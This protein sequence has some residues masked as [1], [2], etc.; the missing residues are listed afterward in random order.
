[1]NRSIH[2]FSFLIFSLYSLSIVAILSAPDTINPNQVIRDGDTIVSAT[3]K[4]ELGFFS[5]GS[6]T[7]RY[8][9]IWYRK[10]VT[11]RTPIWVVNRESPLRQNSTSGVLMVKR[12]GQLVI[13]DES[14]NDTIWSTNT[15]RVAR[16]PVVQLLDSGNLVVRE[17]NDD[18]PENYIWQ[19]F[20]YPTDTFLSSMD[21]GWNLVTGWE[22]YISSW[23]SADDPA[24][25]DYTFRLDITGYPQIFIRRGDALQYRLGP[26]NGMRFSGGASVR[27][28]PPMFATGLFMN[29]SVVYYRHDVID[30]SL[31]SRIT[32]SQ[33]GVGQH[34][35]WV[36]RSKEWVVYYNLPSDI[37]DTYGLCGAHGSCNTNNS[38][39]CG[40]LNRF[41]PQDEEVWATS[42]WSGGCVRRAPLNCTGDV[43]LSYSGIKMPDSRF[44]WYNE[45]LNLEECEDVC[46]RNCS[47]TAYS[48][49]DIRKGGS[50]CLFWL[51][52]LVDI[53]ELSGEPQVIYIRMSASESDHRDINR[54]KTT[55]I[56]A[57][58]TSLAGIVLLGLSLALFI[59]KRNKNAYHVAELELPVYD[60]ST[61]AKATNSFSNS[62]KLG[63]G[64]F[65]SVYRGILEDGKEIAV[66][67]LSATSSQGVDEFKNEVI[68]ISKLQHR[69]LVKL[70]G[71]CIQG[72]EKMLIYEYMPNKSLDLIL[73]D[74]AKNK[75]LDWPKRF[76]IING[77]ARGLLY[78]HQDSRLRIIHRDLKAS[79]I[80]LDDD[81]NPKISDFGLARIFGG[82][83]TQAN[84][85]RVVGTYGYM[86]PEYAEKGL[87][88][89]K[90]DVYSLGV[91]VLEIV[92]GQRNRGFHQ[93]DHHHNLLGHAWILYKEGRPLELVETNT[94]D[95]VYL[96]E[97]RRSIHVALLCVQQHPEDR[98]SMS[99][100]VLM[101][102]SGGVL[103][104]AKQPGF[105]TERRGFSSESSTSTNAK[106]LSNECTIT[107]LEAR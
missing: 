68:C 13:R 82:N 46:L 77:I 32:L 56:I 62:N 101:L 21:L 16:N 45:S 100:V 69:N 61:V 5:P 86:S 53:R 31:I 85:N 71:C 40:C 84:T 1:M 73:F 72:D 7:N 93:E 38:P 74:V 3:Q 107:L 8:V 65:G 80:L 78:L 54:M 28:N 99:M 25:G 90:S 52:D 20:D 57:I 67:R 105:F 87:F 94:V 49:L 81:L 12:S 51:G 9:G 2:I 35:V 91:V 88:S 30:R 63:E 70:L 50:G 10:D 34:W 39:A 66:K 89:P 11:V 22:R 76:H 36:N 43:F 33:S 96:N 59:W 18:Q 48:N 6:S 15:T 27:R 58:S 14:N 92:S 103:P 4:F 26:W 41:V 106:R 60:L 17:A 23:T 79:N 95:S 104:E 29:S 42:V 44:T 19:S 83:E 24:P 97:L 64:G 55:T 98:P 75:Q 47:C 37:C 102:G